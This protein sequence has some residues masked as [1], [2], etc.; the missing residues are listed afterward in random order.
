MIEKSNFILIDYC[1]VIFLFGLIIIDEKIFNGSI[2]RK[3]I[4]RTLD[5]KWG[6]I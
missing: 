2:Y 6:V 3:I 4:T 1:L 5:I